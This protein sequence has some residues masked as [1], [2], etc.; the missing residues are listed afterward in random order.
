MGELPFSVIGTSLS[1]PCSRKRIAP[2]TQEDPRAR[3]FEDYRKE[4][5]EYDREFIEKYDE[6][7][8]TTLIF[9]SFVRPS[10]VRA[11]TRSQA[12][13]FSAVTSAFIIEVQS[14]LQQD[15]NDDTAALLRVLIYKIDNTTFG[16]N[17]PV[18]PQW[19]GP[20]NAIVQVQAILLASLAASLLSAFLA[21]LGKQWLN[22]YVSTDMR[23]TAIERSQNRQRKLDGVITWYFDHVMESLPL[24]LQIA[25]LLLGC[26]L[27]RYFW[28]I[29]ITVASV[30][31]G[32]TACGMIFYIFIIIAGT[33]SESCPYQT[34][35]ARFLRY[36]FFTALPSVF[37][38]A[39]SVIHKLFIFISSKVF[40]FVSTKLR[41]LVQRSFFCGPLVACVLSPS[42]TSCLGFICQA[43]GALIMDVCFVGPMVLVVAFGRT[44]RYLAVALVKTVYHLFIT[45]S[46]R[47]RVLDR[48]EIVLDL[49]CV[50]WM[51]Q[52]SLDK[53]VHLSTMKHLA[54]MMTLADFDPALVSGC[55]DVFVGCIKVDVNN[56]KVVIMQGLE[57]LAAVS[58]MCFLRTFHQLSVANPGSSVLKD[59]RK[60]YKKVF[61]IETD[62]RGLPFYY[63]ITKIHDLANQ[64]WNPRYIRWGDS[65]PS[66]QEC[67]SFTRSVVEV[68]R[69]VY[70]QT[71]YQK[72]PRWSL[73]YALHS[74]SLDPIP[75]TSAIA[76]CLSIIAVD[77]GC[78]ISNTGFTMLD[79][80]C[81]RT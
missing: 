57:Q 41:D 54:T 72:I 81:V 75:P 3:F 19:T 73:R 59:V 77:L 48:Q 23:G 36:T 14:H 52:S 7:L 46:H 38:S 27:S 50:S 43:P 28:G 67:I 60:R 68:A 70:R 2:P 26:A 62:F 53:A 34:P 11:L 39:R 13:L 24:M 15:P 78:D 10:G 1:L 64:D 6:D 21:M 32:V 55:F 18:L 42:I 33:A 22:R 45:I 63:T 74:L 16:D 4:A 44:I 80:R 35:G 25:L 69:V 40:A 29:N 37:H 8:N 58:A 51:L 76:D 79:E 65:T 17:P 47:M 12:G 71:R 31:L 30:V 61:P 9:V 49:Q 56:H 5:E 66:A 20:P